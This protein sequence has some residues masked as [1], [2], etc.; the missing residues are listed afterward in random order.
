MAER[1]VKP[2]PDVKPV[3]NRAA[4][5]GASGK[6]ASGSA[7]LTSGGVKKT[8]FAPKI[9]TERK[10]K[11]AAAEV[12]EGDSSEQKASVEDII[13]QSMEWQS[14]QGRKPRIDIPG[15]SL[16]QSAQV[17]LGGSG[18]GS[19]GD[20]SGP[21]EKR[22]QGTL[23]RGE[24]LEMEEKPK[25]VDGKKVKIPPEDRLDKRK[26]YPTVLREPVMPERHTPV[27]ELN[28]DTDEL[29][30]QMFLMQLPASLP[31]KLSK[32]QEEEWQ[33][34][35]GANPW[36]GVPNPLQGGAGAAGQMG[37]LVVYEDGTVKM[38][39]GDIQFDV[40]KGTTMQCSQQV[41]ALDA[42]SKQ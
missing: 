15:K 16:K 41:A 31:L 19:A 5:A 38:V 1:G 8:R 6:P 24:L 30:E 7:K 36:G 33:R 23:G 29:G 27:K 12:A 18:W 4:A 37:K 3:I 28:L 21:T 17:S 39:L 25:L 11:V 32:E 13:K 40:T 26:Y 14:N 10:K 9:P 20:K 34:P 35:A 2:D 22:K 42:E